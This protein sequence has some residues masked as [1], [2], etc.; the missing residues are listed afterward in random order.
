MAEI[1]TSHQVSS[2]WD[3]VTERI[4]NEMAL[5]GVHAS[6]TVVLVPYAQLMPVARS[7]WER[8]GQGS[9]PRTHFVP[10][11]ET[12]MNWTTSL[13]G[14]EPD[15]DDLRLDAARDAL[16]A[17]SLL[18]R[19]G[20]G[21]QAGALAGRLMEAAWTL[22]RPAAAVEPALRS[23]WG[24]RLAAGLAAQAIAPALERENQLGLLALAWAANSAY[25]TDVLFGAE[26]DL[27]V[28][29]E[30]LQPEPLHE[31]LRV[32][33]GERAVSIRLNQPGESGLVALHQAQDPED[34]AEC[35]AACVL[36][37]LAQGRIPVALVAQ[38]RMLTR[39][40]RALLGERGVVIRDETGWTLSTTRAAATVM[41]LLRAAAWDASTDAV[42][43]WVKNGS[44]FDAGAVAEFE[45]ALR[46]AGTREWRWAPVEDGIHA[47]I[48]TLR[49]GLQ[50]ARVL[51]VWLRDVRSALQQAGQWQSLVD[52]PAGQA[53]LAA[54]RLRQ[55][56]EDEFSDV[57][58]RLGQSAFAAW[59][60]QALEAGSFLPPHPPQAQVVI[61]PLSQLLGRALAA[62]VLPG[63]DEV[64]LPAWPEAQGSWTPAQR[65]LH[66]L[67]TAAQLAAA[68]RD[69]WHYALRFPSIDILW[70]ASESGERLLPSPFVQQLLLDA[71]L[72]CADARV[73]RAL[74]PAPGHM[75]APVGTAV[76]LR[77][78]SASAYEDLRQCPYRFF[79]LRQLGLQESDE[80]D[81]ELGKRDFGNWL[82][83]LLRHFH[84]ALAATP[85]SAVELRRAVIDAAADRAARE[86]G[87]AQSEF[88]PFAASWPR[89]REAYLHWQASHEAGG[90]EFAAAEA[91]REVQ[92]GE[93]VL[94]GRIDR[95]DRLAD[96]SALV[97][98]YKTEARST[99]S[100]R[101]K[102]PCEDTQLAFYAAL[103]DDDTLGAMYLHLA[104]TEATR[105]YVQPDIVALRDHLLAGIL[106]DMQRIGSGARLPALGAGPVC[107]YCAARGLCRKDFWELGEAAPGAPVDG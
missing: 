34:E 88:L 40:V 27:L 23:Q 22:A 102:N 47:Q 33:W 75:P 71:P 42:L 65:A 4:R 18:E 17:V 91:S 24:A 25:R 43:D 101:I 10:R 106:D 99:T 28:L 67:P 19:A 52:D 63:C 107:E 66:G 44:G 94:A 38:D 54:L 85:T 68:A 70:R 45:T 62:V 11:F 69:A 103:L 97:I 53:V 100:A 12:T 105:A 72:A 15:G 90:A 74:Q 61:L 35:A 56:A 81:T 60:G 51:S 76:P 82:H 50:T 6:R 32:V 5:H 84:E 92:L 30:G 3:R 95:I 49:D 2:D 98:D 46:R 13:A 37:Q 7:A 1:A 14:F 39:R 73:D 80:L 8:C 29:L 16:T 59:V 86:L 20:L 64:R 93:V 36:A 79:A 89:V 31:A 21:A 78:L 87:L 57:P 9:G 41:G 96:G 55:G 77:R 83:L 104:E 26:A 58:K 48:E